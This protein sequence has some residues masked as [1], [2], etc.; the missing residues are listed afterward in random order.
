MEHKDDAS[1]IF[2]LGRLRTAFYRYKKSLD[3]LIIAEQIIKEK[4]KTLETN[5]ELVGKHEFQSFREKL[6]AAKSQLYSNMSLCQLKNQTYDLAV[7]NCTKCLSI[8]ANNV[9]ALF[10]RA[11]ARTGLKDYEE[12]INDF[13]RALELEPDNQEIKASLLSCEK[14][15]KDYEKDLASNLKKLFN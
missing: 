11:Q 14:F 5:Q 3:C 7:I 1:R 9:K 4:M 10:R 12:A 8:D 15:R 2:K 6:L 13:N